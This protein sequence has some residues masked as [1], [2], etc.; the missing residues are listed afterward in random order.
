MLISIC[1]I[2]AIVKECGYL[3]RGWINNNHCDRD[4][5]LYLQVLFFSC[6]LKYKICLR[7]VAPGYHDLVYY[8]IK[9]MSLRI[10]IFWGGPCN[11]PCVWYML[12]NEF[13][14]SRLPTKHMVPWLLTAKRAVRF[15]K[16]AKEETNH[17]NQTLPSG[18]QRNI[19]M[20]S[21]ELR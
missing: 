3:V 11:L 14:Y 9:Q 2:S 20:F 4:I 13:Q 10:Q 21:R 1:S 7:L 12:P 19:T 15:D 17:Q 8:L 5:T 16:W 18:S 6:V